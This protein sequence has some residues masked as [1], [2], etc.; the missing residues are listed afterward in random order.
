M[1]FDYAQEVGLSKGIEMAI[2]GQH[3]CAMCSAI[4]NGIAAESTLLNTA[5]QTPGIYITGIF[6]LLS[7]AAFFLARHKQTKNV[8]T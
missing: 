5:L 2:S 6:L 4:E 3:P 7:T 8:H 1:S